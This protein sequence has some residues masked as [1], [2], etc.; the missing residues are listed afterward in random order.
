MYQQKQTDGGTVDPKDFCVDPRTG[1]V[2]PQ[3]PLQRLPSQWEIWEATLD[4]AM[5]QNLKAVEQAV[6][7]DAGRKVVEEEKA[8]V[9]R[10]LVEK[11][12]T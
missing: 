2:P 11:V 7:L 3:M 5:S 6:L 9:W 4:A 8:R 10:D 1:F 12:R